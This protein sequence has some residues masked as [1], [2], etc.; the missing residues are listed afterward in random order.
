MFSENLE[1]VANQEFMKIFQFMNGKKTHARQVDPVTFL[2][3]Y[4]ISFIYL[5]K[6]KSITNLLKYPY[7]CE[8]RRNFPF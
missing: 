4:L 3:N 2:S 1:F 5:N 7:I 8:Y 6:I